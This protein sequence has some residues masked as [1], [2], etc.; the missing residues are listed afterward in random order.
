MAPVIIPGHVKIPYIVSHFHLQAERW[1]AKQ[2]GT[3]GD[4]S[5]KEGGHRVG[6]RHDT[7]YGPGI[8]ISP[9]TLIWFTVGVRA[10]F[11]ASVAIGLQASNREAPSARYVSTL[12]LLSLHTNDGV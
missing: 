10:T 6:G 8:E 11:R 1:A 3:P 2:N 12:S 9:M 7:D 5:W 4:M